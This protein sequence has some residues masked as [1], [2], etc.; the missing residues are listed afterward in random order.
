MLFQVTTAVILRSKFC[1]A[2][3]DSTYFLGCWCTDVIRLANVL[4]EN[5]YPFLLQSMTI[6]DVRQKI[7]RSK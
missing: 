7:E 3:F 2:N 6:L 1:Q 4:A 5:V